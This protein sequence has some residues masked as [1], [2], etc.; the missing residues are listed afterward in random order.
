MFVCR[1]CH[2]STPKWLGKCPDCGAWNTFEEQVSSPFNKKTKT[3]TNKH[4]FLSS[5]LD[6]VPISSISP[7]YKSR[8]STGST[9]FDRV[10]GG[11]LMQG[12]V[13]LLGGEPG[14]GKS[15]LVLQTSAT[16]SNSLEKNGKNPVLYLC[17]EESQ[18]QVAQRAKRLGISNTNLLLSQEY[19]VEHIQ[20]LVEKHM[21]TCIIV[22]SIQ[23]LRSLEIGN[24]S[25]QGT[26]IKNCAAICCEWS[27]Q[28][29]AIVIII[30]HITKEGLIAGP[31]LIEHM[32]DTV[33]MFEK[34][35]HNIR[36]L[37][38]QKNRHGAVDEV[39]V[40][41]MTEHGIRDIADMGVYFLEN[42]TDNIPPG[43]CVAATFE[44][45]R[46]FLVEIQSLTVSTITNNRV[47]S[48][49]ID[50]R[51]I[52]RISAVLERHLKLPFSNQ[53]LYVN[54]AG[55][56]RISE[57]GLELALAL[58]LYSAFQGVSLPSKTCAIGELSLPGEIHSVDNFTQ[59]CR[60][61]QE[62]GFS[63]ILAP[64]RNVKEFTAKIDIELI[65]VKNIED[66]IKYIS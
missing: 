51:Q 16:I 44:G 14:I 29:N 53:N 8:I 12:S 32:V 1:E 9:E 4:S 21:P 33:L 27:Q 3:H 25:G 15:T 19:R 23:A 28:Y 55:G 40:V 30:A 38:A 6:A 64:V 39:G 45:T 52:S 57:P 24:M 56:I 37:Y 46:P 35:K 61:A 43:V 60:Q 31:K 11:G 63:H 66:T 34:A 22:D 17:T 47:Y 18:E 48:D 58:S 65:A 41:Q 2:S 42:R 50:S 10:L 20:N 62:Y 5:S 59:R 26:H 49:R 7:T 36:F 54:V 13:I